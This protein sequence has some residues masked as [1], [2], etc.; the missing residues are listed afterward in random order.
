MGDLKRSPICLPSDTRSSCRAREA[1]FG[2]AAVAKSATAL[3]QVNGIRG[4]T[5]ATQPNAAATE[6]RLFGQRTQYFVSDFDS[7]RVR[8]VFVGQDHDADILRRD[9]GDIGA[10]A[11]G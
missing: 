7:L 5:T 8:V 3:F 4:N 11:A 9:K 1:A 6:P 10:K 2:Y